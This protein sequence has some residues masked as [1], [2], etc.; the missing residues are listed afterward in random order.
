MNSAKKKLSSDSSTPVVISAIFGNAVI[1]I[2]KG[3]GYFLSFSP[4][5]LA[6]ALHSFADT[7]NQVLLYVGIYH[8]RQAPSREYPWGQSS[9]RYLWNLISAIGIFFL[10]FGVTTFHGVS[11]LV[12]PTPPVSGTSLKI[13]LAILFISLII[14]GSILIVA[15]RTILRQKGQASWSTF[16]RTID[17]PTA[18]AVMFEDGIAVMGVL[19]AFAGLWLSDLWS[20]SYPDAIASLIIGLLLGVM[21][22]FLAITNGRLLIGIS[23]SRQ[24]E[25]ELRAF[26]EK[27]PSVE[28]VSRLATEILGPNRVYLSVEV[29]LH[30]GVLIHREQIMKDAERIR[31]GEDP[32]PILVQTAERMVRSVGREINRLERQISKAF[33]N[34][35]SIDLEIN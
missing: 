4:S 24:D 18:L 25:Q 1:T 7:C 32:T 28:R 9:A 29:E 26:I 16:L 11:T 2:A 20:S 10:G 34:I 12:E 13:I 21:G 19:L 35:V 15:I 14:E 23:A 30:G 31:D 22:V 3:F 8:S 5:M 6:E 33:P 27:L 17:D